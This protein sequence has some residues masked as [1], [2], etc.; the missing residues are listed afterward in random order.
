MTIGIE[1]KSETA[2]QSRLRSLDE[3]VLARLNGKSRPA[4]VPEGR[5]I[6]IEGDTAASV[7]RLCSGLVSIFKLLPDGRRQITGFLYPGSFIGV[8][9]NMRNLYGYT[10]ETIT[11]CALDVW[12]RPVLEQLLD[13]EPTL[14]HLFLAEIADEL[15]AAQDRMLMLARRSAEERVAAFLLGMARRQAPGRKVTADIVAIPMRWADI[16]DYLG[17]TA[18]TVSRTLS[19]FRDRDIVRTGAR[20]EIEILD[21]AELEA[22]EAGCGTGMTR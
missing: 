17:I 9:F 4:I 16:A 6:I 14:R 8:T 5:S 13:A 3:E 20:A 10:A 21:R 11:P 1:R 22:I 2:F 7:Y 12:S 19:A 15:T 18:E